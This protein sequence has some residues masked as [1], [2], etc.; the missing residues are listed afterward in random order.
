MIRPTRSTLYVVWLLPVLWAGGCGLLPHAR[1]ERPTLEL[2]AAYP[3]PVVTPASSDAT[4]FG[5]ADWRT[6]FT[7]PGLQSLI[8]EALA[9]G[10]DGLLAA[11]QV[12]EAEALANAAGAPRWPSASATVNTAPIARLPG[13]EISSSFLAGIGVS[14]ELDL[15]GRYARA[16]DAA[17]VRRDPS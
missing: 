13:D 9:R 15:W 14:W 16:R 6:V 17:R 2:S 10:P 8:D 4:S 7:D 5:E 1:I 12:R 11:A 3:G